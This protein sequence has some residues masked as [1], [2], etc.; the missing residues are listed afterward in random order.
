MGFVS[1]NYSQTYVKNQENTTSYTAS[2]K[3]NYVFTR[4]RTGTELDDITVTVHLEKLQFKNQSDNSLTGWN[5]NPGNDDNPIITGWKFKITSVVDEDT[6][7]VGFT[8]P[9][10]NVDPSFTYS[11]NQ[12]TRIKVIG[13]VIDGNGDT[14]S[15]LGG[16]DI[17]YLLVGPFTAKTGEFNSCT[18]SY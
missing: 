6:N 17:T 3:T 9:D 18:N 7:D 5:S 1:N 4:T 12:I 2:L 10:D 8:N 16:I 14:I 15:N 13:D 11:E